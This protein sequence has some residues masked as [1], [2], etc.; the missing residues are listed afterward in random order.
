MNEFSLKEFFTEICCHKKKIFTITFIAALVGLVIGFSIPKHYSTYIS[1]APELSEEK[2]LGGMSGL[3][4]LAGID[5]GQGTDAIGPDLYPDVI[6]TNSFLVDLLSVKVRTLE[7]DTCSYQKYMI[8]HSKSPWWSYGKIWVGKLMK[9]LRPKKPMYSLNG[10][11]KGIDPKCLSEEEDILINGLRSSISCAIDEDNGVINLSFS[12]QDPLV[13][14]MMVDTVMAKLQQFITAYRT[15][16]AR[17]DLS[18][19]KLLEDSTR[20][21]YEKAKKQ[22]TIFC[23][24]HKDLTMQAY[25]SERESLENELQ[26]AFSAYSQVKQQAQLAQAKVQENTPAFTIVEDSTL[27]IRPDGPKKKLIL[28]ACI[29]LGFFGSIGWIYYRL[30]FKKNNHKTNTEC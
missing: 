15:N 14:M 5:L 20:I 1:L 17:V 22:Y 11:N 21:N 28:F 16:K 29:F 7:G 13:S 27:P 6:A 19:Y 23:D 12:A 26:L 10:G 9:M 30:L 3:A 8:L 24:S 4:S 18:Y 2:G 25:M